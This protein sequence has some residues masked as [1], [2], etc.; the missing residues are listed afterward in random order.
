[1]LD[2]DGAV[3]FTGIVDHLSEV[4]PHIGRGHIE[5]VLVEE[6]EI[7]VGGVP[8][9]LVPAAVAEGVRERLLRATIESRGDT[10][11]AAG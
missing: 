5:S 2:P 9:D 7:I 3:P 8:G 11:S 6:H 10:A 4:F 1:M